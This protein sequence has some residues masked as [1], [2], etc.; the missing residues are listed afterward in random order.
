MESREQHHS[1]AVAVYTERN[2]R[3]GEEQPIGKPEGSVR[4]STPPS[5]RFLEHLEAPLAGRARLGVSDAPPP[6][7]SLMASPD[8]FPMGPEEEDEDEILAPRE[9]AVILRAASA[10]LPPQERPASRSIALRPG[11]GVGSSAEVAEDMATVV[12]LVA[13]SP[14]MRLPPKLPSI[15]QSHCIIANEITENNIMLSNGNETCSQYP[16]LLL[17]K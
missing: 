6:P 1:A 8:F 2:R 16:F 9:N 10:H 11:S 12:A 15:F 5:L 7:L 13:Q 4:G 17:G 14:L 3:P